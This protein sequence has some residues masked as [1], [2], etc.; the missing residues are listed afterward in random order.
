MKLATALVAA[1][2]AVPLAG[3][4]PAL[5]ADYAPKTKVAKKHAHSPKRAP[6]VAGWTIRGGYLYGD[7]HTPYAY[8]EK[9]APYSQ[10]YDARGFNER[11][12]GGMYNTQP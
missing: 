2:I 1:I 7:Q 4:A 8:A 11:V 6:R 12:F 5:A 3:A 9:R 10:Y